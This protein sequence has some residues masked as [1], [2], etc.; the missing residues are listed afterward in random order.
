ME[1][2]TGV[3]PIDREMA[4]VVA[5]GLINTLSVITGSAATICHYRER[6]SAA[7]VT[8]LLDGMSSNIRLFEDVLS[9]ILTECSEAFAAAA[10]TLSLAAR[11][12]HSVALVD[13]QGVLEAIVDRADVLH[14]GLSSV[15]RGLSP[16]TAAAL[17]ELREARRLALIRI[18]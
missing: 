1:R 18:E 7:E 16:E 2:G 17:D 13:R 11:S 10:T 3:E 6:L 5:H 15:V 8:A 9:T 4:A 12:F 14:A